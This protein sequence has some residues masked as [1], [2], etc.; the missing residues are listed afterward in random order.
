MWRR[1]YSTTLSPFRRID[2][3][4]FLA[5]WKHLDRDK[6]YIPASVAVSLRITQ[7]VDGNEEVHAM[8]PKATFVK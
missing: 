8:L 3:L 4:Y 2:G 7:L 6:D 5:N 1:E